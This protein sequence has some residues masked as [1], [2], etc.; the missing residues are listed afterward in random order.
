MLLDSVTWLKRMWHDVVCCRVP[1]AYK[2]NY[3]CLIQ[4]EFNLVNQILCEGT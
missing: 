1:L 3:H 2:G 4:D